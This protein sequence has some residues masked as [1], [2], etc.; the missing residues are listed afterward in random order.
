[1]P[2][3]KQPRLLGYALPSVAIPMALALIFFYAPIEATQGVVQKIFYLHLAF[4]SCMYIPLFI[5]MLFA[6]LYLFKAKPTFDALSL[7]ANEVGFVFIT[8]VLLSGAI[9]AKPIWGAWWTW[10]ARLTTT[11]LIWLIYGAYLLVRYQWHHSD[12]AR[13]ASA[14]IAILGFLDVPLIHYAVVLFRG[15]HP[16]VISKGGLTLPMTLT[17]IATMLSFL[18]LAAVSIHLRYRIE[19]MERGYHVK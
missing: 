2:W 19:I 16:Q 8:G 6:V 18:S 4:V 10:D 12:A 9:W 7:A 5:G 13:R 3:L 11:L 15:I 1:M 17:L 14:I